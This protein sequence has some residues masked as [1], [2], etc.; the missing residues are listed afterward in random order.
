MDLI[1]SLGRY[2]GTDCAVVAACTDSA[3]GLYC[4]LML[5]FCDGP[6]CKVESFDRAL[7]L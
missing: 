5:T 6:L 1:V 3:V 2:D 4:C 7:L